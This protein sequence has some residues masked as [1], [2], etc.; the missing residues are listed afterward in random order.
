MP[1]FQTGGRTLNRR[2]PYRT[3]VSYIDK[4]RT[5]YQA[6]GYEQPYTWACHESV[7][8][9]LPAKPLSQCRVGLATTASWV[10]MGESV[11]SLMKERD[12]YAVPCDPAP[13][14]LFTDHLFWDKEATHTD[15]VESFLPLKRLSEYARQGRIGSVSPR[16]Y[17]VPTDYSQG[18]T[19]KKHAPRILEWAR[20]DGVD[21]IV[22]SAL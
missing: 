18:R 13:E 14:R 5:Y 2:V 8:F 17:G 10:D 3:F 22:L 6:Q 12:C 19:I 7:P 20:E 15:D 1:F 16:F 9:T 4:S 21:A 11:E